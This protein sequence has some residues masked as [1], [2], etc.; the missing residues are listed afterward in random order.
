MAIKKLSRYSRVLRHQ[1]V[2][3]KETV[4]GRHGHCADGADPKLASF[5]MVMKSYD[6]PGYGQMASNK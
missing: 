4:I 5:R 2:R 1:L 3:V 6:I